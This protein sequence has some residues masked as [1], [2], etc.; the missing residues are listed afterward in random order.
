MK[1]LSLR[2]PWASLIADGR[3]TIETRSW[4]PN[5]GV[6]HEQPRIA[7]HATKTPVDK[8]AANW[9]DRWEALPRGCVVCTARLVDVGEVGEILDNDLRNVWWYGPNQWRTV[10]A[11]DYGSFDVGRVL[12]QLAEIRVVSPVV[13]VS[14]ARKLWEVP[15]IRELDIKENEQ[16]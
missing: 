7:I 6:I 16:C 11:D 15:A 1:A 10:K 3:K 13:Y 14:G 8:I 4:M 2:Q 9:F 5:I 12:F